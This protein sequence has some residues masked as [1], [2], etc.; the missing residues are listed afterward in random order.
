MRSTV[1]TP[2]AFAA[3]LCALLR[4]GLPGLAA[5]G[6]RLEF[7]ELVDDMAVLIVPR[8]EGGKA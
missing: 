7:T 8:L 1:T 3:R 4:L 6:E 2:G 5:V